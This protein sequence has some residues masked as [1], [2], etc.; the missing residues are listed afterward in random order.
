MSTNLLPVLSSEAGLYRYLEEIKKFPVL[1][2]EEEEI[3]SKA[4]FEKEDINA[5]HVLVTSH[6]RLVVKIAMQFKGY[7]L[8]VIDLIS[9][10]NIG[11]MTAVKKFNPTM[12]NRLSTYAMWWIKAMIQ[13][14]VLKSWSIVKLGTSALHK[15]LF[16]NLRKIKSKIYQANSGQI[17][18]N[19]SEI[20]AK[21]L[22]VSKEDVDEMSYRFDHLEESLNDHAYGEEG[23]E[24]IDLIADNTDN[25]ETQIMQSDEYSFR[26]KLL[27][28]GLKSLNERERD[29]ISARKLQ[30]PP[31]KLDELS[32][33]YGVSSERIR[34]IEERA[35][36]KLVASANNKLLTCEKN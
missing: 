22:D 21:E 17:P 9:E 18:F 27:D 8:P 35:F 33:I 30:D 19:E 26:K 10:G 4:W 25:Q 24:V 5:A 36:Q 12:G 34:Q 28:I 2:K 20:I 11:L 7:G 1:T 32:K 3:L 6:L 31:V 14:F 13:D 15:K 16:F 29:I 23:A